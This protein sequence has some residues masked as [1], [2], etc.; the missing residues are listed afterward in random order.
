MSAGTNN[1]AILRYK[2]GRSLTFQ[3]DGGFLSRLGSMSDP[4]G[5]VITIA[6]NS[7]NRQQ[8]TSITDPVG[9]RL[10]FTYDGNNRI[11]SISDP[12]GRTVSYT[13][14]ASGTLA[15]VIAVFWRR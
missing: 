5:N 11:K 10:L 9:R 3:P 13:Y 15:T 7:T 8:I 2:D 4:N 12:I 6:R 1:T 14:N